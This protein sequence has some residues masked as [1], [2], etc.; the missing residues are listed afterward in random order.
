MQLA[1]DCNARAGQ[2]INRLKAKTEKIANYLVQRRE[3][4]NSALYFGGK[5]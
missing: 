4:W 1:S 3:I 2:F 5:G